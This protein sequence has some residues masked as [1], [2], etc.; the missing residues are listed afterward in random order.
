M[1]VMHDHL[2]HKAID[3][4]SNDKRVTFMKLVWLPVTKDAE[5]EGS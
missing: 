2:S 3:C 1:L 5:L 4:C